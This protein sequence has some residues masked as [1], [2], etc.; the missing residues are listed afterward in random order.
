[1]TMT[2]RAISER[3]HVT[4]VIRLLLDRSGRL[5][6]GEVLDEQARSGGRFRQWRELSQT[7]RAHL[8]AQATGGR[9]QHVEAPPRRAI[10]VIQG[11]TNSVPAE[12]DGSIDSKAGI[13]L[14]SFL[15]EVT[16]SPE[17]LAAFQA[18]AEG[19]L[20]RAGLSETERD[21]VLSR[22]SGRIREAIVAAMPAP[23]GGLGGALAPT[24]ILD[25]VM[26]VVV[27]RF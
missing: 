17:A 22:D 7:I 8:S 5:L 9:G 19:T 16:R 13:N 6:Q 20:T 24:T 12:G 23:S 15:L 21:A 1:M 25:P 10:G 18:N 26:I 3:R 2:R 27:I 11:V 14:M 4:V